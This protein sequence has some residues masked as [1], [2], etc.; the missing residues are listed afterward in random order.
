MIQRLIH[1][2][3]EVI[4]CRLASSSGWCSQRWHFNNIKLIFINFLKL[5]FY[6]TLF[7]RIPV[8]I[9]KDMESKFCERAK[10][11]GY[12]DERFGGVKRRSQSRDRRSRSRERRR[13]R[14]KERDRDRERRSSRSRERRRGRSNSRDHDRIRRR[15]RDRNRWGEWYE[16]HFLYLLIIMVIG[17][18]SKPPPSPKISRDRE[19]KEKKSKKGTK[20][21][22][23]R[24]KFQKFLQWPMA[25]IKTAGTLNAWN[26]FL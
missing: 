7:P 13:S 20:F 21:F 4:I 24:V 1:V 15:S 19:R 2:Q 18:T 5:D 26:Y 3:V 16:L 25:L 9:Q 10:L 12:E 11:Y 14:S 8:P 22:T 23:I 6:G 17:N